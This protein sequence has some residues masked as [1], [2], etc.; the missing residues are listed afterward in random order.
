MRRL[1]FIF[2]IIIAFSKTNAQSNFK[3]TISLLEGKWYVV[4]TNFPMWHKEKNV[5][6]NLNY[7]NFRE[8]NGK[9]IFDDCVMYSKNKTPKKIKGKDKQKNSNELEFVWRGNGLLKL[10]RSKWKVIA[11]DKEGRWIAIYSTRTLVSPEGVDIVARNKN[12]SE[13]EIKGIIAHLDK[14][15]I[16]KP[17]ELLK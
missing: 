17:I 16:H 5:N 1:A 12:L 3:Y 10:F 7:T 13:S 8:N 14:S 11:N 15:Y 6:P 9:L 4:A 2:V